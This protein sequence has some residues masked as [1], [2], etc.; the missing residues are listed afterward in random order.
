[1]NQLATQGETDAGDAK[2]PGQAMAFSFGDP[3]S[4]IDRRELTEYF[5][6]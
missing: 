3:E 1:M 2:E 4:V 5:E 6:I